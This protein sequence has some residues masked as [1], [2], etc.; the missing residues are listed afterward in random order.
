M[1]IDQNINKVYRV[2]KW[3]VVWPIDESGS[4]GSVLSTLGHF[5]TTNLPRSMDLGCKWLNTLTNK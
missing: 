3:L 1:Q 5:V 2:Q 4:S